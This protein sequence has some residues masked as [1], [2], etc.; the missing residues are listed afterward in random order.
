MADVNGDGKVDIVCAHGTASYYTNLMAVF[1]NNGGGNFTL[2]ENLIVANGSS[3]YSATV[4]DVNGDGWPDLISA[5]SGNST[6]SVFTNNG[7]N[8]GFTLASTVNAY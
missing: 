4:A 6:L 1:T 8:G 3:P 5:N 7:G 2:A